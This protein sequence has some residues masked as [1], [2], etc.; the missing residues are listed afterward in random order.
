[1]GFVLEGKWFGSSEE[2]VTIKSYDTN[3][4][5]LRKLGKTLRGP[6]SVFPSGAAN[7][8]I[9]EKKEKCLIKRRTVLSNVSHF[10]LNK[11]LKKS[12]N[13]NFTHLNTCFQNQETKW[14]IKAR[15][16]RLS[17]SGKTYTL[18]FSSPNIPGALT[19]ET[20]TY[21]LNIYCFWLLGVEIFK[22]RMEKIISTLKCH[23]VD[24][25]Q[26]FMLIS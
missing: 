4:S 11:L 8:I 25:V 26:I 10:F 14:N 24:P 17:L 15:N 22:W 5:T 19:Q 2:E 16:Q 1:M 12:F 20:M 9:L 7:L 21:K 3:V 23:S 6:L 13:C 18:F